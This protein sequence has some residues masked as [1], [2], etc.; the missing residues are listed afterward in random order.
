MQYSQP[1]KLTKEQGQERYA[2]LA[3]ALGDWTVKGWAVEENIAAIR[4]ELKVLDMEMGE[5]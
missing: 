4:A 2:K 1:V 5:T 3:L